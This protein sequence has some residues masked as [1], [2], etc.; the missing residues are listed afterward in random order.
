MF[1]CYKK[2]DFK[3]K[4]I[5]LTIWLHF[6]LQ[7]SKQNFLKAILIKKRFPLSRDN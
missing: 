1:N 7:K 5:F 2:I 3:N 4:V 6:E